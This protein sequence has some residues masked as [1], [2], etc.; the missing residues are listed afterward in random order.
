MKVLLSQDATFGV[1]WR[2]ERKLVLGVMFIHSGSV[3]IWTCPYRYQD[4]S[5]T[6]SILIARIRLLF[7]VRGLAASH[8]LS[9]CVGGGRRLGFGRGGRRSMS[10]LDDVRCVCV[11]AW[12]RLTGTEDVGSCYSEGRV[13]VGGEGDSEDEVEVFGYFTLYLLAVLH[14]AIKKTERTFNLTGCSKCLILGSQPSNSRMNINA[15]A[16]QTCCTAEAS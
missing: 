11:A 7:L 15:L 14:R 5:K 2:D 10:R 12:I 6:R 3:F 8:S 13:V 16:R 1:G 4:W 9:L